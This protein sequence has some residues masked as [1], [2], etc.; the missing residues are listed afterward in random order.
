FLNAVLSRGPAGLADAL[1]EYGFAHGNNLLVLVD[2]FVELFRVD[3]G[4]DGSE[5]R[6]FVSLLLESV[7]TD[8]FPV[9]VVVTMRSDFLGQCPVFPGL[10]EALNDSQYLTP[11]LNRDQQRLAIEGPTKRFHAEIEPQ[12]VNRVLNEMRSDPD[13]LPLMQHL[14]MR[15]WLTEQ[16]R[17]DGRIEITHQQYKD[18]GGFGGCVQAHADRIY[19]DLT[20]TEQRTAELAF[21]RLTDVTSEGKL[22]R[23][24]CSY[25]DLCLRIAPDDGSAD[26]ATLRKV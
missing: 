10:P 17:S 24:Q 12:V 3:R 6:A 18:V 26:R 20:P 11:R 21:R 5:A 1:T 7:R 2:Q 4:D 15:M 8:R 14:M 22:I 13:Q 19:G 23:R 25:A 16:R 9:Y